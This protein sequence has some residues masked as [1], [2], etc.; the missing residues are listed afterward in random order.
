MQ[1]TVIETQIEQYLSGKKVYRKIKGNQ[2]E[3]EKLD[4]ILINGLFDAYVSKECRIRS[5]SKFLLERI[6]KVGINQLKKITDQLKERL[7]EKDED[8]IVDFIISLL[9]DSNKK[10][11]PAFSKFLEDYRHNDWVTV[12]NFTRMSEKE[13]VIY[14]YQTFLNL[15]NDVSEMVVN[16]KKLFSFLKKEQKT[17]HNVIYDSIIDLI[18]NLRS[19]KD[20]EGNFLSEKVEDLS[21]RRIAF[22]VNVRPL[23]MCR[24]INGVYRSEA[25]KEMSF[26]P[27]EGNPIFGDNGLSSTEYAFSMTL[28]HNLEVFKLLRCE[29]PEY[30]EKLLKDNR[31]EINKK[32]IYRSVNFLVHFITGGI[33]GLVNE[34]LLAQ[35]FSLFMNY[36]LCLKNQDEELF[37]KELFNR[38]AVDQIMLNY[39][40]NN[41]QKKKSLEMLMQ[42]DL[43]H[44]FVLHMDKDIGRGYRGHKVEKPRDGK[45]E[46]RYLTIGDIDLEVDKRFVALKEEFDLKNSQILRLINENIPSLIERYNE[47]NFVF[48]YMNE[49]EYEK[50]RELVQND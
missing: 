12:S 1:E 43:L 15:L 3:I 50:L 41:K 22:I 11:M 28:F 37:R 25:L 24:E 27:L 46:I 6:E 9:K 42:E 47:D 45:W 31:I 26:L 18:V 23:F 4:L 20:E 29:N 13:R 35:Y 49:E 32:E 21:P 36:L 38:N 14:N 2:A 48:A 19:L 33:K 17:D 5:I 34:H 39:Y 8:F 44:D 40:G 10:T 7:N 16:N 30:F